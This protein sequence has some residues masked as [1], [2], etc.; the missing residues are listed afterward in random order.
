MAARHEFDGHVRDDVPGLSQVAGHAVAVGAAVDR[1]E[2][3][4]CLEDSQFSLIPPLRGECG[5]RPQQRRQPSVILSGYTGICRSHKPP[6]RGR[7]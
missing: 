1:T 4:L 6:N 7:R 2:S 5:I 3:L